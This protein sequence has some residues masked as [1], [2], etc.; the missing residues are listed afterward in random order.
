MRVGS[1]RDQQKSK[2][3]KQQHGNNYG[4]IFPGHVGEYGKG[5]MM[6]SNSI[7]G[8]GRVPPSLLEEIL[9]YGNND[10][11]RDRE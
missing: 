1:R 8:P 5:E 7:E 10:G 9:Q 6:T 3:V 4:N 11:H 2:I